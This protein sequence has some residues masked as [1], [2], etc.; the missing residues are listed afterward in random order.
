MIRKLHSPLAGHMRIIF[1]LPSCLWADRIYLVGD[2]NQWD[3]RATPMQQERDGV[4]R[5]MIDLKWGARCEFRYLIDGQWRTD[6]HADGQTRNEFGSENSIVYA[7]LPRTKH[8]EVQ[9]AEQTGDG[10]PEVLHRETMVLNNQF[11]VGK[12]MPFQLR[13]RT[14]Q[15][16]RVA[17]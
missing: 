13:H 14:L 15:A 12:T 16:A 6:Y 2:F 7:E 5:A 1:E 4:W 11:A 3:E 17:A 10:V 8:G 9:A